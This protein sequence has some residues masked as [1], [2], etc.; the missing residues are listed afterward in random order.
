MQQ[1]NEADGGGGVGDLRSLVEAPDLS[2]KETAK[3]LGF[4]LSSVLRWCR[5]GRIGYQV[6]KGGPY[7][8][9]QEE[10]RAIRRRRDR[11][12]EEAARGRG[13]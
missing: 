13:K 9:T 1:R 7:R 2:P 6:V 10:V 11:A 8:I 5:A 12:K 4:H 3:I